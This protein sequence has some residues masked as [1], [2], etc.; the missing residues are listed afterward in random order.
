MKIAGLMFKNG[1]FFLYILMHIHKDINQFEAILLIF[2]LADSVETKFMCGSRDKIVKV[3]RQSERVARIREN[4][5]EIHIKTPL[6]PS[7][8]Q[9][10]VSLI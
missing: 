5:H 3:R 1:R 4:R 6:P 7:S 10:L 8:G 2:F 9:I